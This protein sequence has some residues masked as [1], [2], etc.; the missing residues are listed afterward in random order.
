MTT[1][2][3]S[4]RPDI[5]IVIPVLNEAA[6][7]AA[8]IESVAGY[9]HGHGLTAEIIVSDDGSSDGTLEVASRA[10]ASLPEGVTLTTLDTDRHHGKGHAVRRGML[11]ARGEIVMFADSGAN[12]PWKFLGI[13]RDLLREG[14]VQIAHGSRRLPG[15]RIVLP[16]SP[17]RRLLSGAFQYLARAAA[18]VPKH[19]TDTQCGFK[20]YTREAARALYGAGVLDG[21]LFDLE[22][23]LRAGQAGY[24]ISEFPIEWTCDRDSRIRM[25][26]NTG[27]IAGELWVLFRTFRLGR[28]S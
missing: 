6:K 7:I 15:S 22:I 3:H 24:S 23:I 21:F 19:L 2:P 26:S 25:L 16:Q 17:L 12:V 20:I 11:A 9:C 5:S 8:D 27:R 13:G 14:L 28:S 4:A 10:G 18:P 1:R